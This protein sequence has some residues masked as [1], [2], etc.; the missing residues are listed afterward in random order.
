MPTTSSA[1]AGARI[2]APVRVRRLDLSD[3]AWQR[4]V[5]GH[6]DTLGYHQPAWARMI[7]RVYRFD[8]FCL[9][10]LDGTGAIRGGVPVIAT[11]RLRRRWTSLPFTDICPP[12]V[13]ADTSVTALVDALEATRRAAGIRRLELRDAL[14]RGQRC[15]AGVTHALA[16]TD[17]ETLW[18]GLHASQVR[19]SLRRAEREGVRIRVGTGPDDM[20]AYFGLHV[21]T[22]RRLG[23]PAQPRRFFDA[24]WAQMIAAGHGELL[25]AEHDGA[26]IAGMVL[27]H[28]SRTVTYK[29][30]ASLADAWQYRPNHAL[31]WHAIRAATDRG[32]RT[33][34]F[35]RSD[36]A[37]DGLRGFKASWAATEVPLGYTLLADAPAAAAGESG[38]PELAR[39]VIRRAPS[40]VCRTA[41]EILYRFA[42]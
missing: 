8:A 40:I 24:V 25:L 19:R 23:V 18:A 14:A 15:P 12:L 20:R 27:L 16:L 21:A 39:A 37:D 10:L 3:P 1:A 6:P 5:D 32:Y 42:A 7:G 28:G 33:F 34:D 4:F 41:G 26:A 35:G 31:F 13:D 9:A 29:Y 38:T 22:R 30:G 17:H 11:G 2:A 36:L